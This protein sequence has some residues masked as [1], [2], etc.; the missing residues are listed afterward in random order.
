MPDLDMSPY[1]AFVWPAWTISALALTAVVAR[2]VMTARR[3]K[4]ELA[5]LEA[6]RDV[7]AD[8]NSPRAQVGQSPIA[9]ESCAQVGR[10]PVAPK[11]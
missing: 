9:P 6:D 10:S 1:A 5:R 4:T 7:D 11:Q 2:A 8:L 3:W